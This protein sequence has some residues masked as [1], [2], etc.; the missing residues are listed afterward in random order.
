VEI[1]GAGLARGLDR[2]GLT[3]E[4]F[5]A[6]PFSPAG[7]RMY[8]SGDIARWCSDALG[9]ADYLVKPVDRTRL[10]ET[11]TSIWVPSGITFGRVPRYRNAEIDPP[12]R[13]R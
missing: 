10:I 3:S 1:G 11:L 6:D 7:S 13:L 5:V 2:A 12:P 4:R 9:A 8:R